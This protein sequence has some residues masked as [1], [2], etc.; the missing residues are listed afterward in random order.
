MKRAMEIQKTRKK[1]RRGLKQPSRRP[2]AKLTLQRELA[3]RM[4]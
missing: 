1:P 4:S 2:S 3:S